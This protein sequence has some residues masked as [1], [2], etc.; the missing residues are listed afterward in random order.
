MVEIDSRYVIK[1]KW[2]IPS[3]RTFLR[4]IFTTAKAKSIAIITRKGFHSSQAFIPA[5]SLQ[6]SFRGRILKPLFIPLT[7]GKQ[8]PQVWD[9]TESNLWVYIYKYSR[10]SGKKAR[11]SS[12]HHI[13][14]FKQPTLHNIWTFMLFL[15]LF[16]LFDS[17][18]LIKGGN[19]YKSLNVHFRTLFSS[20]S[21]FFFFCVK[22]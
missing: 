17:S 13:K 7:L 1:T 18:C 20:S 11:A 6:L 12:A 10:I 2:F 3:S 5:I 9:A 21:F 14:H 22:G 4:R 8:S 15:L 16:L 19:E